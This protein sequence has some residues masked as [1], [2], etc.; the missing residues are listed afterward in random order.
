MRVENPLPWFKDEF[1]R[2][3][4]EA[5]QRRADRRAKQFERPVLYAAFVAVFWAA[6]I[7]LFEGRETDLASLVSLATA[8]VVFGLGMLW[9]ARRW[10]AKERPASGSAASEA[11]GSGGDNL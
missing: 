11:P 10:N 4:L 9:W 1:R 3:N 5:R 8:S 2:E 7:W 6:S